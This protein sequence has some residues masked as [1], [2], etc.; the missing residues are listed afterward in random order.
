MFVF[1]ETAAASPAAPDP[2]AAGIEIENRVGEGHS[3]DH[4]TDVDIAKKEDCVEGLVPNPLF[5]SKAMSPVCMDPGRVA[6]YRSLGFI[7]GLAVRTGVPLPLSHLSPKWWMLVSDSASSPDDSAA[8]R[9]KAAGLT[10]SRSIC[11]E[12]ASFSSL[13]NG[14]RFHPA[15]DGVFTSLGRL[16]EV[17]LAKEETEEI[18]TDAKFVAP[19]SN[20]QVAELLPGG[21][22]QF[23]FSQ[24]FENYGCREDTHY[25]EVFRIYS[26]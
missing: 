3:A 6:L 7:V 9:G 14:T 4:G 10:R 25:F 5:T 2:V 13:S 16:A 11:S 8:A 20:G 21:E 22:S 19:L 26:L 12:E 15:I 18:L 23:S 17:G 24:T 1:A